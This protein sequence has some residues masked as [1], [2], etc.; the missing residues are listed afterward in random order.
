MV[1]VDHIPS[2]TAA[3][4]IAAA[5]VQER[6]E[7]VRIWRRLRQHRPALAGAALIGVLVLL[8]LLP[9]L[10]AP[11]SAYEINS[12]LRGAAPSPAH[13]FG[14]D[15]VGRDVL[16]R[17]IHGARIAI[18]VGVSATSLSLLVGVSVGAMAGYFGGAVDAILMRVVD[19]LQAFPILVLLIAIAAALRTIGK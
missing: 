7:A 19:A 1:A 9:D 2:T 3:G 16:S 12:S 8:G 14:M 11:Y 6:G 13:P 10:V 15:Q 17:V 18:L 5:R 4:G